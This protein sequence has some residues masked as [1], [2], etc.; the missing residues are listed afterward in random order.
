LNIYKNIDQILAAGG[1]KEFVGV[2]F[3]RQ[4]TYPVEWAVNPSDQG[5]QA[6]DYTR[7]IPAWFWHLSIFSDEKEMRKIHPDENIILETDKKENLVI[8]LTEFR[9]LV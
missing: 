2:N 7:S 1:G 4:V 5:E 8:T 6:S 9:S 3:P